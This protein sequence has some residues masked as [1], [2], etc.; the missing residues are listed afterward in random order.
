MNLL[1][2]FLPLILFF[3]AFLYKGIYA[4]LIV[5]MVALPIGLF[6]KYLRTHALD[7]M[8]LWSTILLLIAGGLTLYFR[9]PLFLYWKPTVLYWLF[10]IAFLGSQFFSK[11]PLV[12]KM[13]GFID[14]LNLEKI[15]SAQWSKLNFSWVLFFVGVG[16][17]NIYVAYNFEQATWVKLKVFGMTALMFVFILAQTMW[18]AKII[19]ND[20]T[21]TEQ[22]HD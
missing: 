10:A 4:A 9:N 22:E 13:F 19:G 1:F 15:T 6:V 20:D 11:V 14:G 8:Y 16:A 2:E 3:G 12:Q 7:K 21:D 5:L 17:L 18:I